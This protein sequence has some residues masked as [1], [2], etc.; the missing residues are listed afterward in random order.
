MHYGSFKLT[1][2]QTVQL[3]TSVIVTFALIIYFTTMIDMDDLWLTLLNLE[4]YW[5]VFAAFLMILHTIVRALRIRQMVGGEI[6]QLKLSATC[7]IQAFF[8][9]MLPSGVSQAAFI[10]LLKKLHSVGLLRSFSSMVAMRMVDLMLFTIV[11]GSTGSLLKTTLEADIYR[12]VLWVTTFLFLLCMGFILF[13]R[14]QTKI[15]RAST[16]FGALF[17]A[18]Y[19]RILIDEL[20]E[21]ASLLTQPRIV[22]TSI[23]NWL[24]LFCCYACICWSI[25]LDLTLLQG[26]FAF[27]LLMM[28]NLLPIHGIA[29]FGTHHLAWFVILTAVGVEPAAA[30]VTAAASHLLLIAL[31][32][33]LAFISLPLVFAARPQN[34]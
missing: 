10:Y 5:F 31:Y 26:L 23:C 7:G 30:S 1:A 25:G 9:M 28:I 29:G 8:G 4:I 32:M 14:F 6:D 2:Q 17:G 16:I 27:S 3:A 24:A 34:G 19:F 21:V 11:I 22:L 15:M 33:L 18:K 13:N 20:D 12:L